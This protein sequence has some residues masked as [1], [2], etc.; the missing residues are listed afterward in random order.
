MRRFDPDMRL[1]TFQQTKPSDAEGFCLW[2]S[3]AT[4]LP[5]FNNPR[6]DA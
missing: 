3:N 6:R 2:R 1:H 5:V 4:C